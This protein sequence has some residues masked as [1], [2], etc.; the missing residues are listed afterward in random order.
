MS[1]RRAL[2]A[3]AALLAGALI[4]LSLASCEGDT[5]EVAV[6]RP[7]ASNV[8]DRP[9]RPV[10][11]VDARSRAGECSDARPVEA[12][13]ISA[14]WC[15]LDRALSSAPEG[16]LVL[17]RSGEYPAASVSRRAR[18]ELLTFRPFDGEHVTLRGVEVEESSHLRFEGFRVRG[19]TRITFGS[20]IQLV[21]N[22]ISPEGI[23]VRPSDHLLIEGNRIHDLTY[24]GM[25]AGAGYGVQLSG[26]WSDQTRPQWITDVTIRGNHFSW[27]PADAI[28]AGTVDNLVI[29]GNEFDHVTPFLDPTEH[30][31][32]IQLY[33][34]AKNVAVRRNFFHD[35]PRALIAKGYDYPGLV[36]ENNLMARLAGI[37][38]NIYDAPGVRIVNNTIWDTTTAIRFRDLP[39]VAAEMKDAVVV[40][41]ILNEAWFSPSQLAVED[42]N[43]IGTPLDGVTYGP[44]DRFVAPRFA[45]PANL[46][47]SLL[48]DSPAIDSGT[49]RFSTSRDRLGRRRIDVRA[50]RNRGAG[51]KPYVDRG[52]HEF[53]RRARTRRGRGG[54]P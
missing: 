42:Y 2:A 3:S 46:D 28:Q 18:S 40:N 32:G 53:T 37:A 50:R 54:R 43:L 41:N 44:H 24:E 52:A 38:L 12:V 5:K 14:P 4:V 36:I 7:A 29:E 16:G 23:T 19:R 48:P 8:G 31:D 11:Y 45:D 51:R 13:S 39:E 49:S 47:Y 25:V 17:V 9:Q 35:Q 27:V 30:S 6:A 20:H 1:R 22:D 21:G 10:L 34:T 15:S 33:G 26:G